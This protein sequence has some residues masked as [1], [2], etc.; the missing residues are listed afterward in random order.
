MKSGSNAYGL[1]VEGLKQGK[2]KQA[3]SRLKRIKQNTN[4]G[5]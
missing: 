2:R 1:K 4:R 5:N 3:N